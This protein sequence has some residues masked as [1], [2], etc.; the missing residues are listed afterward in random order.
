LILKKDRYAESRTVFLSHL[1][2]LTNLIHSP[3]PG[4]D[5]P[6]R[7]GDF[8]GAGCPVRPSTPAAKGYGFDLGFLARYR[9]ILS[10]LP[11]NSL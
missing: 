8:G 11:M 2:V 3:S 4:L 6:G 10:N 9:E 5:L 7:S 1:D